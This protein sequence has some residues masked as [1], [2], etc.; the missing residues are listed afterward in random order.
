MVEV[1]ERP[2]EEIGLLA[3]LE[4]MVP[5]E[6]VDIPLGGP[7]T[8][9]Q[10]VDEEALAA[11]VQAQWGDRVAEAEEAEVEFCQLPPLP[12]LERLILLWLEQED[13]GE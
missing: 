1:G 6:A 2:A 13:L 4:D 8:W 9:A 7:A 12:L 3:M 5:A 11:E 10:A